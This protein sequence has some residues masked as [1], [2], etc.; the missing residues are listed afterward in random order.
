[1]AGEFKAIGDE[2][3]TFLNGESFSQTFTAIRRNRVFREQEATNQLGVYVFP[4]Q[5]ERG[6]DTRIDWRL[7]HTVGVGLLK[8]L[9]STEAGIVAEEDGLIVLADEIE[10]A[11]AKQK[12][13]GEFQLDQIGFVTRSAFSDELATSSGSFGTVIQFVLWSFVR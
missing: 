9:V 2:L 5:H 10:Q 3:V 4:I 7:R 6:I 11:I 8:K 13:F 12:S 1:M